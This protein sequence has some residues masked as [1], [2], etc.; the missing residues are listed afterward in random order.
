[1]LLVMFTRWS[2]WI[3]PFRMPPA[4]TVPEARGRSAPY[5]GQSAIAGTT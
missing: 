2:I 4:R 1:M 5:R 3:A